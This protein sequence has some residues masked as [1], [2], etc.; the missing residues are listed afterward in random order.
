[1]PMMHAIKPQTCVVNNEI[2]ESKEGTKMKLLRI[3][4]L[5]AVGVWLALA[6][7]TAAVRPHVSETEFL[8][9]EPKVPGRVDLYVTD[10]FRKHVESQTDAMDFKKWEFELGPL[11]VDSF[12]YALASKFEEVK[13]ML[14]TPNFPLVGDTEKS[15][16][17]VV[18]PAFAGFTCSFP[19]VF[20][21]E[22]YKSTVCFNVKVFDKAGSVLL[23]NSY[24][25]VGEKRGSV[26]FESAGTAA[27]PVTAQL[28]VKD[29]VDKAV[30]DI[31][32]AVSK[33]TNAGMT[34]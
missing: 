34:N 30:A 33:P 19:V 1:M 23:D 26:G 11:A 20:K 2:Q 18:E 12:K 28:A 31:V 32:K 27:N 17:A 29:A 21:F 9:N 7:C 10:E 3:M 24:T 16:L 4:L 5:P 15:L 8:T 6:G 14:G 25:G 13:V 22:T